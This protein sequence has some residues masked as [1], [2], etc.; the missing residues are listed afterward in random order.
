MDGNNIREWKF[1]WSFTS[2]P[3]PIWNEGLQFAHN[4]IRVHCRLKVSRESPFILL[5]KRPITEI[6]LSQASS[7]PFAP[8]ETGRDSISRHQKSPLE[9][10]NSA[11]EFLRRRRRE[12]TLWGNRSSPDSHSECMEVKSRRFVFLFPIL[13]PNFLPFVMSW[14]LG[15]SFPRVRATIADCISPE[16][17]GPVLDG[18]KPF[19]CYLSRVINSGARPTLFPFIY[20]REGLSPAGKISDGNQKTYRLHDFLENAIYDMKRHALVPCQRSTF[21]VGNDLSW[22][23]ELFPWGQEVCQERVD[24]A[25][26][27]EKFVGSALNLSKEEKTERTREKGINS[28]RRPDF[29]ISSHSSSELLAYRLLTTSIYSLLLHST[30][31]E[32]LAGINIYLAFFSLSH[33]NCLHARPSQ[34]SA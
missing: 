24:Q 3:F 26:G 29:S 16:W 8:G 15:L 22:S 11:R 21:P 19:S 27:D 2:H 7:S 12:E 6:L 5:I 28:S 33:W 13:R 25:W 32:P 4:I 23:F 20:F 1:V 31:I 17:R 18:N 34:S 9:S 14:G 30:A 10:G